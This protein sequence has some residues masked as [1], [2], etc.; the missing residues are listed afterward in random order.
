[1]TTSTNLMLTVLSSSLSSI[2][3]STT[4]LSM[5]PT[6]PKPA[7]ISILSSILNISSGFELAQ[8]RPQ[9][10]IELV[11]TKYDLNACLSNCSNNG[12]CVYDSAKDKFVCSCSW[13]FLSGR[14][15]EIDSRGC[16]SNPCLNNATC[17]SRVNLN[18]S[19]IF[20]SNSSFFCSCDR[21]HTGSNCETKIDA[22]YNETCSNNGVCYELN[23][24]PK[25]KCFSFY[26][27]DKCENV[28]N[29][30]MVI[31]TVIWYSMILAIVTIVSFYCVI[32]LMD[33]SKFLCDR[34]SFLTEKRKKPIYK[35]YTYIN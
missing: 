12:L 15:C 6:T 22:C 17:S 3:T 21:F 34:K 27:G 11:K 7:Y 25:C 10:I 29:E 19:A 4:F 33:L 24:E 31:K 20:F 2:S 30:L 28:S 35:K 5:F 32:A 8:L 26:L 9:Q 13:V 1:L 23:N 16:S 18:G 14:A